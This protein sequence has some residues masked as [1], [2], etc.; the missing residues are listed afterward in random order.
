MLMLT[1]GR[2]LLD[3]GFFMFFTRVLESSEGWTN[4]SYTNNMYLNFISY[5]YIYIYIYMK[6]ATC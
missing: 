4:I 1:C 6:F 3:L 5:I 2:P